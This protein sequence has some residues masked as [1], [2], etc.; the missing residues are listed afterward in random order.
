[1]QA[2]MVQATEMCQLIPLPYLEKPEVFN[3]RMSCPNKKIMS[4]GVN[5]LGQITAHGTLKKKSEY[6]IVIN[7]TPEL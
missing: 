1:M 4:D 7:W 6:Q 3:H 5:W 2:Y